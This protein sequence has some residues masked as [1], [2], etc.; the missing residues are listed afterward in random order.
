M[1][2]TVRVRVS[3]SGARRLLTSAAVQK[4]LNARAA[5]IAAAAGAGFTVRER[6]QRRERYGVQVRTDDETG[7]RAQAEGNVLL[8]A[9]GAGR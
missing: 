4:E 9:L 7:R 3:S 1:G 8:V 2:A 5:R 6:P